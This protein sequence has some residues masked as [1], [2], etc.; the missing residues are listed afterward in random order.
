M[1]RKGFQARFQVRDAP[2]LLQLGE[3]ANVA[4]LFL[5]GHTFYDYGAQAISVDYVSPVLLFR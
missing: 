5:R 1:K 3:D 4:S 2:L